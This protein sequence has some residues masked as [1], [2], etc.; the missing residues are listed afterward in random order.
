MPRVPV[1][2]TQIDYQEFGEGQ[3]I[4]FC[5]GAGGNLLSW[6]QQI[7]YFSQ[8]YR[9]I[10]FSH[11]GFGH[12]YDAPD[13]PGMESFVDDL[14]ALLDHLEIE[15]AHLVAQS[16]GGR[17]ALGFAIE[18][19][20]RTRSLVLADTTGGMGELNVEQALADWRERQGS[21]R[22]LAFR[23][24]AGRFWDT[25]P[26]LANL[27]LQISRTNPP[28]PRIA[29]VLSG[30]P[31]GAELSNLKVP[32]LFV[33]GDEDEITPPHVIEAAAAHV[34]GSEVLRV[35]GCGHSVYFENPEVFNF[36]VGRFIGQ[37]G[38]PGA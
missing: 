35:P 31:R 32:T 26:T 14:A 3:A 33:V 18:Y 7:P 24:L 15:S 5:H 30:G 27:Y 12:S 38:A 13:G 4:V 2:G 10:T 37:A 28:R 8:E 17:T 19:T 6:W 23:A 36:E 22:E 29:G 16:M 11:R 9:C 34:P 1:N 20:T 21:G 25:N